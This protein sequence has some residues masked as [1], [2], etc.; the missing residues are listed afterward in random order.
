MQL[1]PRLSFVPVPEDAP[2]CA[3]ACCELWPRDHL[4]AAVIWKLPAP[5][6]PFPAIARSKWL[7]MMAMAFDVAYGA[8]EDAAPAAEQS[9]ERPAAN[10]ATPSPQKLLLPHVAAGCDYYIDPDGFALCDSERTPE[11]LPRSTPRRRVAASEIEGDE[12][13]FDYRSG[14]ARDRAT[15]VWA[16]DTV[17]AI[18]G[19][20][21]CGAG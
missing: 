1:N 17:G 3:S 10:A 11:G 2:A 8:A 6:A 16:D 12:V 7:E 5:G 4:V 15:I 21:F 19:M 14:P 13:I 18:A 9:D 20:A